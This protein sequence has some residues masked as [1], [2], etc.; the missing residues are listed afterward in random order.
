M[1][2]PLAMLGGRP[3][4][5]DWTPEVSPTCDGLTVRAVGPGSVSRGHDVDDDDPA[6]F[7]SAV[8][9]VADAAWQL[10]ESGGGEADDVPLPPGWTLRRGVCDCGGPLWIGERRGR[11]TRSE[12]VA[13]VV[14]VVWNDHRARGM[15][16]RAFAF[17]AAALALAAALTAGVLLAGGA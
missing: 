8:V 9:A 10:W 13:E 7:A 15:V 16:G 14:R 2:C 12:R 1:R 17:C 6:A 11:S 5:P 4:P 3:L